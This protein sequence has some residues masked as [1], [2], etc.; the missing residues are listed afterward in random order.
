MKKLYKLLYEDFKK[1]DNILYHQNPLINYTIKKRNNKI[2]ITKKKN[3]KIIF[4]KIFKKSDLDEAFR[5]I[6]STDLSYVKSVID[7][8]GD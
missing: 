1:Y 5:F 8:K 3:N 7:Y 2:Y 6:I 4:N